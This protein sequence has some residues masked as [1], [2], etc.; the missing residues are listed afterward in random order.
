MPRLL[1]AAAPLILQRDLCAISQAFERLREI[2]AFILH[3]EGEDVPAL[4]TAE[5]FEDL[6][7]WIDVEARRF[8]FVKWAERHEV[9]AG[10]LQGKV[11]ANNIYDVIG[12]ANLFARSVRN[13]AGHAM[14]L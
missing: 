7:V 4:L 12:S 6:E 8:L 5:A 14:K 13:Q 11:S 10:A 9:G 3:D 2:H 1:I